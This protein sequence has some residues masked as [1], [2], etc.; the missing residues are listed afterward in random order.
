[1][2]ARFNHTIIASL[3]S[4]TMADFYRDLLEAEDAPSWGFFTNLTVTDGVMPQFAAPPMDFPPQHY[5]FLV[6]DDHFDRACTKIQSR[7]VE[8]WADPQR[9]RPGQTNTEHGG[10]GVYLLDPSGHLLEL[11]TRP[12]L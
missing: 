3:D 11:I 6:D 7:G 2:T 10:R 8:H 5:A 12:Y 4:A 1:M 9:T